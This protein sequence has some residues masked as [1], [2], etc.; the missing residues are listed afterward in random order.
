MIG[1]GPSWRAAILATSL[2]GCDQGAL[3]PI[4]EPPPDWCADAPLTTWNNFGQGFLVENC[5]PC[6][7]S[8]SVDRH[9]AP[10]NITFDSPNAVAELR[11][12]ILD[13]AT[14]DAPLMPPAGGI[15]DE[16]RARLEAWLSCDFDASL[17]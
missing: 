17:R 14:G 7:A 5:Q 15:A 3:E 6:H 1:V 8:T 16:D 13:N 12:R 9:D 11:Q 2:L 4:I 10:K